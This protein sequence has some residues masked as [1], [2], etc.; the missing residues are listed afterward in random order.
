MIHTLEIAIAL[1]VVLGIAAQWLAWRFGFPAI[2]LLALTGIALGPVAGVL[3]PSQDFGALYHTLVGLGVA[4]VLFEGGF[5][6]RTE[7]IRGKVGGLL[8]LV[9][10]GVLLSWLFGALAAHYVAG[11][12][13]PLAAVLGAILTVT[14]PTVVG[15]L[16]RHAR[17][18]SHPANLFKWEGIIN[19]PI[20]ALLAI[21]AFEYALGAGLGATLPV[22]SARL[23][24]A[25]AFAVALGG[26]AG[27][28]LSQLYGHGH[29]PEFLKAPG[30]LA[31]VVLVYVLANLVQS[32]AGLLAATAMGVVMG[33]RE[34]A[35]ALDLRRFKENIVV[36]LVT[37]LFVVLTADI[38]PATLAHLDWRSAAYV[39]VVLV[40]VRPAA[41]LLSTIGSRIT[42]R[43]RVLLGWVAPRGVVAAAMAGLLGKNLAEAGYQG[44][45]LLF[46]LTFAIILVTVVV[47]GFTIRPLARRLGLTAGDPHGLLIIG[48]SPWSI[49][50]AQRL[51]EM[52]VRVMLADPSEYRLAP[53]QAVGVPTY[54]GEVLSDWGRQRLEIGRIGYLLAATENPSYNALACSRFAHELGRDRVYQLPA[55]TGVDSDSPALSQEIE[56]RLAFSQDATPDRMAH[57]YYLGWHFTADKAPAGAEGRSARRPACPEGGAPILVVRRSGALSLSAPGR[58]PEPRAGD[59][60]VCYV[61]G[62]DSA[63]EAEEGGAPADAGAPG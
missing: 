57:R 51:H 4:V 20:G 33:N 19:D 34:L 12:S 38:D 60:L 46:P 16:L 7:E 43:E 50:L 63:E 35:S 9:S 48:A 17:L 18:Q 25:L 8:R 44:A 62:P 5:S 61:P 40:L 28:L 30:L 22:L 42:L 39:A 1:A 21:L 26:G 15:P 58:V 31:A 23:V 27:W 54:W 41:V 56:G 59:W 36:F 29:V 24:L 53:A 3:H 32:E 2:V 14:G 55:A 6:L 10:L 45:S 37:V 11:L 49:Q 13:W 47:H 52:G